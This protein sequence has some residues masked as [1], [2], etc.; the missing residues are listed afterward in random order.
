MLCYVTLARLWR[1]FSDSLRHVW[2]GIVGGARSSLGG[3]R[4]R[5]REVAEPSGCVRYEVATPR[6][7]EPNPDC[8]G[9]L[10]RG[11]IYRIDGFDHNAPENKNRCS[12]VS[13]DNK[14]FEKNALYYGDLLPDGSKKWIAIQESQDVSLPY[15]IEKDH[16][17]TAKG[18]KITLNNKFHPEKTKGWIKEGCKPL[19]AWKMDK[20]KSPV[21]YDLD[22]TQLSITHNGDV[23]NFFI[24]LERLIELLK[25]DL[26]EN[27]SIA[28]VYN[29]DTNSFEDYCGDKTK[30][31]SSSISL[32]FG[33]VCET[34]LS[35]NQT[36]FD[37]I[38]P[39][40]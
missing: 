29:P 1:K 2:K 31:Y 16:I 18:E 14:T 30:R 39:Q 5:D 19:P 4:K 7:V 27:L 11:N 22:R 9:T 23:I 35:K 12:G 20:V 26:G 34:L 40:V 24:P 6:T 32:Y 36:P 38:E 33:Q 25:Q 37:T 15:D 10:V 28:K 8:E 17:Y 13:Y 3:K 21:A